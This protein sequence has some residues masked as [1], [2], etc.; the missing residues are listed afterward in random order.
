MVGE[1]E[2]VFHHL[3]QVVQCGS[4]AAAEATLEILHRVKIGRHAARGEHPALAA[5]QDLKRFINENLLESHRDVLDSI[6][7]LREDI[8]RD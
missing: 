6:K 1:Q 4:F 5:N 2:Y 3:P 8:F 7:G